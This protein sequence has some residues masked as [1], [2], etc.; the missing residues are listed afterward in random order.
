[1]HTPVTENG[2]RAGLGRAVKEVTERLSSIVRLEL[3]LAQ[4]ELKNKVSSLGM[5]IGLAVGALVFG[6]YGLGFLFATFA[7]GL[8][9]VLPTWLALLIV[10]LFLALIALILGLVAEVRSRRAPRRCPGAG[11]RGGEADHVGPEGRKWRQL[12]TRPPRA[13][14]ARSRGAREAR[15]RRRGAPRG[16]R[17]DGDHAREAAGRGRRRGGNR[18]RPRGRDRRDDATHRRRGREGKVKA[19]AGRFSLVRR[20]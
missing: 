18:L 9:T 14:A 17:P 6:L 13:S 16:G 1:M 19:K 3:Q 5:G 7:A 10:T 2:Q 8:A 11:D 15:R 12:A 4:L 20:D